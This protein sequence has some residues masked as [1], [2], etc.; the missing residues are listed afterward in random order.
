MLILSIFCSFLILVQACSP[1]TFPPNR[2]DAVKKAAVEFIKKRKDDRIGIIVFAGES[3][4]QC[5]LTLD[6]EVLIS[7]VNEITV[8]SKEH[9][10]TAIGMAITNGINR[11]RNSSVESKVMILLSDGS[12]NAGEI[13]PE[14]ASELA[15]QFNVR[16]YTIG[17]G[18]TNH[19]RGFQDED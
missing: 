18:T 2:L 6:K 7:L 15:N 14:T 4:I 3:F 19:T 5:S 12:N 13:D 16:I 9:D 10:G 17:A 1:M 11:F 8:A